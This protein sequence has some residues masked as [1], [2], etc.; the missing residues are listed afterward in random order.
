M[1]AM[2]DLLQYSVS[3]EEHIQQHHYAQYNPPENQTR[4]YDQKKNKHGFG[5]NKGFDNRP[6]RQFA[7][8]Y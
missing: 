8:D 1:H 4:I 7:N 5:N 2:S 3:S 6:W